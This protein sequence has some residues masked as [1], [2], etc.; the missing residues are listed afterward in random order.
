VDGKLIAISGISYVTNR[1]I[2]AIPSYTVRHWWYRRIL[3]IRIGPGASICMGQFVWFNSLSQ[4]RRDGVVIGD[5]AIVN[6]DC[7]LDA[8]APLRIGRNASIS[9][10][11]T[12]L[13]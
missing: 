1:I 10:Y 5:H 4:I 6:R 9:A 8:R 3:G 13:T 12:I 2:S 7:C 11:V